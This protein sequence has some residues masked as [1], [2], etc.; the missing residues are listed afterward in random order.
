M[1]A[2]SNTRFPL[3]FWGLWLLL[4]I[5]FFGL[6]YLG[7]RDAQRD[8]RWQVNHIELA[9]GTS[10]YPP[11]A[12]DRWRQVTLPLLEQADAA[13]AQNS[14][15]LWLRIPLPD[16]APAQSLL[17]AIPDPN[18]ARFSLWL[19]G[20][21][22]DVRGSDRTQ[23]SLLRHPIA[24]QIPASS[25][26]N[27]TDA[28][29][30]LQLQTQDTG[31]YITPMLL[32]P[33]SDLQTY[34]QHRQ[35]MERTLVRAIMAMMAVMSFLMAIIHRMRY[36]QETV[37]GWYALGMLAWLLHTGQGQ[38]ESAS[39]GSVSFWLAVGYVTLPTF[40]VISAILTNRV[41]QAP[42]RRIEALL[43]TGL[44]LGSAYI[45]WRGAA[46]GALNNFLTAFWIPATIGVGGYNIYRMVSAARRRYSPDVL[47]LLAATAVVLVV[48][49]R[50]YLYNNL[51]I[52]PGS[53]LY[54]K[55]AAGLVLV[56]YSFV[57]IRRFSRA[58]TSAE[59]K[60]AELVAQRTPS[61]LD[62]GADYRRVMLDEHALFEAQIDTLLEN[63]AS[64]TELDSLR[65]S[66]TAARSDI[67]L[68][69][70]A[71]TASDHP[72]RHMLD[73]LRVRLQQQCQ[74]SAVQLQWDVSA[75]IA[76]DSLK[77]HQ[78]LSLGRLIQV[79]GREATATAT[80]RT[81]HVALRKLDGS[82]TLSIVNHGSP[83]Q[84]EVFTRKEQYARMARELAGTV[85]YEVTEDTAAIRLEWQAG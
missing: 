17:L 39:V 50:D 4:C 55:Y 76:M 8:A 53:S 32:G 65:Q 48:G 35:F 42:A 64:T 74:D 41:I 75:D 43:V 56:V 49:I 79:A 36:R 61:D 47:I 58:L 22:F 19:D 26:A 60:N 25:I 7:E 16:L 71:L 18:F 52:V 51:G 84:A 9:P 30:I 37:Y 73:S 68:I 34:V 46:N 70:D 15:H 78:L 27:S 80:T 20:R 72:G 85:S 3:W 67:A 31:A 83:V 45:F 21:E 69:T 38:L 14:L 59:A 29:L 33:A 2:L 10:D 66:L 82:H 13:S 24:F 12:P 11:T 5:V 81:L 54:L 77:P 44:V 23:V 28:H 63:V 6:M 62:V 57:L 1:S 40:V